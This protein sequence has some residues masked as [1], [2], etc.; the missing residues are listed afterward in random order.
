MERRRLGDSGASQRIL[1]MAWF[2]LVL[3]VTGL[4][5]TLFGELRNLPLRLAAK[6]IASTGFLGLALTLGA[7]ESRYGWWILS[8]LI[9]GFIGDVALLGSS[10][11]WFL[12]GL[13]AFLIGHLLYV[14][15]FLVL[16][17]ATGPLVVA[18]GAAAAT[19]V[20]IVR[21]LRPHLPAEMRGPVVGY[22]VIISTMIATAVGATAAGGTVLIVLGAT[23]FYVSDLAV[24]RNRFVSPGVVNRLWGLP[25]YYLAQLVLAWS[26]A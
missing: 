13:V 7:T 20:L 19:G 3:T 2:F 26:V 21:W 6:P 8:G 24:A 14:A 9:F 25:L 16:G 4:A 1:T 17:V 5:S 18:A 15:A 10:R 23:A 11:S 12:S 22:V